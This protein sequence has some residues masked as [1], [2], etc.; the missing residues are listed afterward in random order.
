MFLK[1]PGPKEQKNKWDQKEPTLMGQ[2]GRK[3]YEK[4]W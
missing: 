4:I 2:K 1:E 3:K